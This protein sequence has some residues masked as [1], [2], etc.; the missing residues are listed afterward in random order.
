MPPTEKEGNPQEVPR[1]GGAFSV[2]KRHRQPSLASFRSRTARSTRY[3]PARGKRWGQ[4]LKVTTCDTKE[5]PGYSSAAMS[6]NRC[7]WN[8]DT[9]A[10]KCWCATSRLGRRICTGKQPT[11][12]RCALAIPGQAGMS[13][14]CGRSSPPGSPQPGDHA[15][16]LLRIR[17]TYGQQIIP[18]DRRQG[19]PALQNCCLA[20]LAIFRRWPRWR[21]YVATNRFHR[22]QLR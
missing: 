13:L 5:C 8:P 20:N 21:R 10:G 18:P 22:H 16:T 11:E 14:H 17:S 15:A 12:A 3:S 2:V 1:L 6:L 19:Q 9:A 7:A 4:D